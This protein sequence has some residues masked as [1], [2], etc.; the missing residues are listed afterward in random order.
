MPKLQKIQ[1]EPL[2]TADKEALAV[3]AS[4]AN[5]GIRITGPAARINSQQT[6]GVQVSGQTSISGGA[7]SPPSP[8]QGKVTK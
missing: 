5:G 6:S 3:L 4:N 2:S 1:R 7:G 8:T